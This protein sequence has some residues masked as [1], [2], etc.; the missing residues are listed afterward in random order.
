MTHPESHKL[1]ALLDGDLG[2]TEIREVEEHL[3]GCASCTKL[4]R[5]LQ[6]VKAIARSLPD[7]FPERD[8]WP[9]IAHSIAVRPMDTDVIELHPLRPGMDETSGGRRLRI[10]YLQAA[11]AVI[12]ISLFSGATG[13]FLLRSSPEPL[14]STTQAASDRWMAMAGQMSPA[15]NEPAKEVARLEDLLQSHRDELDPTTVLILEEN[16]GVIDLAIAECVRALE[17]DPGNRFL[18]DHLAQAVETKVT[19][20]RDATAFVASAS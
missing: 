12:A 18:E 8:L 15:L 20:L 2:A 9:R 16:L 6:E 4:Y 19:F 13:A 10:S 17:A 7:R 11:A 5:E 14:A 1:S 3:S